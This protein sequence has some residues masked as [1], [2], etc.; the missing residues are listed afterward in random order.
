M[1]HGDLDDLPTMRWSSTTGSNAESSLVPNKRPKTMATTSGGASLFGHN[2]Q[3]LILTLL[4]AAEQELHEISDG[5]G[6]GSGDCDDMRKHASHPLHVPSS[7]LSQ[8]S[9]MPNKR[10]HKRMLTSLSVA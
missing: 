6:D 3:H 7:L 1:S 5:G 2:Q 9:S 10:R 8:E 4:K